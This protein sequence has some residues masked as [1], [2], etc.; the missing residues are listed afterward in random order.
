[1]ALCVV[2]TFT[3]SATLMV[4]SAIFPTAYA[5]ASLTVWAGVAAV[6]L[7]WL[8]REVTMTLRSAWDGLDA[9][10]PHM[11]KTYN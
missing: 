9:S 3:C 6:A 8:T 7:A 10:S 4:L 1:M 2:W 5:E 11:A